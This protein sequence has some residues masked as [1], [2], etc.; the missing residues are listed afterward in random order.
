MNAELVDP[1]THKMRVL[2]TTS[3]LPMHLDSQ[4]VCL[5]MLPQVLEELDVSMDSGSSIHDS[6]GV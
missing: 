1:S 6:Q 3:L 4:K 5:Q 2:S